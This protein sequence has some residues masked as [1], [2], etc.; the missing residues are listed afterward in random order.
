MLLLV[1]L[2]NTPEFLWQGKSAIDTFFNIPLCVPG[3]ERVSVL[4]EY[5]GGSWGI[6]P[7]CVSFYIN[8]EADNITDASHENH[9]LASLPLMP[10]REDLIVT[11]RLRA[12]TLLTRTVGGVPMVI[13]PADGEVDQLRYNTDPR[14]C[15]GCHERF[16]DPTCCLELV[17]GHTHCSECTS[18]VKCAT[19]DFAVCSYCQIESLTQGQSRGS[20]EMNTSIVGV[21]DYRGCGKFATQRCWCDVILCEYHSRTHCRDLIDHTTTKLTQWGDNSPYCT[22]HAYF[23]VRA[24]RRYYCITHNESIC[25]YCERLD[26]RHATCAREQ[27]PWLDSYEARAAQRTA[28]ARRLGEA[29]AMMESPGHYNA[30]KSLDERAAETHLRLCRDA[31]VSLANKFTSFARGHQPRLPES[32]PVQLWSALHYALHA[33]EPLPMVEHS[34]RLWLYHR[35]SSEAAVLLRR[36][37]PHLDVHSAAR[38]GLSGSLCLMHSLGVSIDVPNTVGQ[39]PLHAASEQGHAAVVLFCTVSVQTSKHQTSLAER[40]FMGRLSGDTLQQFFCC[41]VSAQTLTHRTTTAG[42]LSTRRR[43]G[44]RCNSAIAAQPRGQH[45]RTRRQRFGASSRRIL[46]AASSSSALAAQ[47]RRKHQ[48]TRQQRPH[49]SA[50]GGL[51]WSRRYSSLAAQSRRKHQRTRQRQENAYARGGL[52]GTHHNSSLAAPSR[53]KHQRSGRGRANACARGVLVW[54][55]RN[56][57]PAAPSRRK[58]RCT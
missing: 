12:A 54:A 13:R 11:V 50:R 45:R 51:G 55:R 4:R 41:T 49:T 31:L 37:P 52:A 9:A 56:S 43:A 8:D 23:P 33:V 26:T 40:L 47:F 20:E 53:G 7:T 39:T 14:M 3:E 15:W 5:I 22:N 21:C 27:H 24:R 16:Q 42:P 28:T 19:A 34:T 29:F 36:H 18:R 30:E 25:A 58:H 32:P 2:S 35:M 48:R 38:R 6:D 46:R 17:C 57:S 1:F 44:T 10:G